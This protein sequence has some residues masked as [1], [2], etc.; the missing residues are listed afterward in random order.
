LGAP[1]ATV[2]DRRQLG[3]AGSEVEETN[4]RVTEALRQPVGKCLPPLP[5]LAT[6]RASPWEG[7][8]E[9]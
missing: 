2:L 6:G 4:Q 1:E 7:G 5:S 8:L 9:T 3:A